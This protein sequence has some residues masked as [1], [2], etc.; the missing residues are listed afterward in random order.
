MKVLGSVFILG[1]VATSHVPAG[2]AQSQVYPIVA[3]CKALLASIA[4][5]FNLADLL[6][7]CASHCHHRTSL[8]GLLAPVTQQQYGRSRRLKIE[9]VGCRGFSPSALLYA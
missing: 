4:A 5:G 7:V 9:P 1:A 3:H 6:R 8:K 2:Q